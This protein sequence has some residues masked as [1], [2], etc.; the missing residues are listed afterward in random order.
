MRPILEEFKAELHQYKIGTII[1]C[2]RKELRADDVFE[3]VNKT[4]F[5][6]RT[7]CTLKFLLQGKGWVNLN[8]IGGLL[9][10]TAKT[11]EV[12][13]AWVAGAIALEEINEKENV[14]EKAV[15]EKNFR[16]CT[17]LESCELVG[18][19]RLKLGGGSPDN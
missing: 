7:W 19:A 15:R 12:F 5:L 17:K 18:D 3:Y 11:H 1:S 8:N 4:S 13:K 16:F 6:G 14:K 9:E 2:A 10:H